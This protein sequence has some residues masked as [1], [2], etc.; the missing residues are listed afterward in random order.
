MCDT[1]HSA[2][3]VDTKKTLDLD[4]SKI[5]LNPNTT[6]IQSGLPI[7]HTSSEFHGQ[8]REKLLP[9]DHGIAVMLVRVRSEPR[10]VPRGST[11]TTNPICWL[12]DCPNL[13]EVNHL[14]ATDPKCHILPGDIV[15][16]GIGGSGIGLM[17]FALPWGDEC[18]LHDIR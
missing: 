9:H 16:L 2:Q 4:D 8:C 18:R 3:T 11:F 13:K 6:C 5:R 17:F 10:R 1:K 12:I 14:V 15:E 7:F